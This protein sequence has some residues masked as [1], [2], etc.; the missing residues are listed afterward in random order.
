MAETP[1]QVAARIDAEQ[2][3]AAAEQAAAAAALDKELTDKEAANATLHSQAISVHN[4]KILIPMT[5]DKSANNYRRWRSMFLVVLGKYNLQ[6]HVLSDVAHPTRS[7]WT[8]MDCCVVTWIYCTTSNDLQQSLMLR[9]PAARAAWVYLEDEFLG[10]RESRA[11]LM[12]AEFRSF[13]HGDLNVTD[14]CRRLETMAA[15]LNDFGDPIGDRQLVLT[16]LRG[17]NGKFKH[18]VSNF[19]MQRPFPT[20]VEARTQLLLEEIDVHDNDIHGD[21]TPASNAGAQA[22]VA[23]PSQ[24][25]PPFGSGSGGG[26]GGSGR[27]RRRGR[28]GNGGNG[29]NGGSNA[30][31]NTGGPRPGAPAAAQTNP[32]SGTVQLWPHGYGGLPGHYMRPPFA[33]APPPQSALHMMPYQQGGYYQPPLSVF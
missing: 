9:N 31:K 23:A 5:L 27:N 17:L 14:Y 13:K 25:R 4:I 16:L 20:F 2:A 1:E 8:T 29:G 3:A 24:P 30:P 18:M 6:D 11:L 15:S 19:K 7:A 32:G 10:Q 28:G 33:P 12:E 22:L 21:G 26:S